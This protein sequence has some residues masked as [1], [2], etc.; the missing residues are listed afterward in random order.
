MGRLTVLVGRLTNF[1]FKFHKSAVFCLASATLVSSWNLRYVYF[2]VYNS[3]VP[4]F[5]FWF[6]KYMQVSSYIL[7]L[8]HTLRY[9]HQCSSDKIQVPVPDQA[10]WP[11]YIGLMLIKRY[12]AVWIMASMESYIASLF[13][14]N[15]NI[16]KYQS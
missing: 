5:Y 12:Q 6:L 16:I 10:C 13:N 3:L 7:S 11:S 15:Q 14:P 9:L 1:F 4:H 8:L 2:W